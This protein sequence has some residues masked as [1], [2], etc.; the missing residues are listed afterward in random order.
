MLVFQHAEPLQNFTMKG[1]SY[2]DSSGAAS[3]IENSGGKLHFM[4]RKS[5][6]PDG[7]LQRRQPADHQLHRRQW[8]G[9]VLL[10]A[11]SMTAWTLRKNKAKPRTSKAPPRKVRS[12]EA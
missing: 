9:A 8:R 5:Q 7:G 1:A 12:L 3:V 2:T 4:W 11:R 10:P 6:R